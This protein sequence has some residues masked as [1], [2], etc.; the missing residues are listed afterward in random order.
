MADSGQAPPGLP[1]PVVPVRF[2]LRTSKTSP[3]LCGLLL[4]LMAT[5]GGATLPATLRSPSAAV[6]YPPTLAPPATSVHLPSVAPGLAANHPF[7]SATHSSQTLLAD[8]TA[9]ILT[10]PPDQATLA[11][12]LL[13]SRPWITTV[14][15][16]PDPPPAK[17]I[18]PAAS[19]PVPLAATSG[20]C[21]WKWPAHPHQRSAPF[22]KG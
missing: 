11:P 8:P 9:L 22:S 10:D 15:Q 16:G 12:A 18:H 21:R 17:P 1:F 13:P 14:S 6:L 5:S 7:C 3:P 2:S 4:E 20:V 19:L